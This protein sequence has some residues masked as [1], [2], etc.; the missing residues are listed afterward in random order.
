MKTLDEQRK[1]VSQ[2]ISRA[3]GV[4]LWP[5]DIATEHAGKDPREYVKANAG[6][7]HA[8]VTVAKLAALA[9]SRS[10]LAS[11]DEALASTIA[12]LMDGGISLDRQA[13]APRDLDAAMAKHRR[14]RAQK[15]PLPSDLKAQARKEAPAVIRRGGSSAMKAATPVVAATRI[16][17]GSRVRYK[18]LD[19]DTEHEVVLAKTSAPGA[20]GD[21]ALPLGSPLA[22]ALLGATKGTIVATRLGAEN[23]ELEVVEVG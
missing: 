6:R 12:D 7:P 19:D 5:V 11:G 1:A 21:R 20:P 10:R 14:Q 16:A 13:A 22:R 18:R 9:L 8:D 4:S 3:Y 23:V 17:A 15:N 2:A